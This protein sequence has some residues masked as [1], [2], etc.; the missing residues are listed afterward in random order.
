M[1]Q[2]KV[3]TTNTRYYGIKKF[4][5]NLLNPLTLNDFIVKDSFDAAN[6]IQQITKE[7]S[8]SAYEFV[9]FDVI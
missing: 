5:A 7:L 3:D 8:D 6:K 2:T 9:S 1:T 4:L